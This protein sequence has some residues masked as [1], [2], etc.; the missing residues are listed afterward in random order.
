MFYMFNTI[1]WW[2]AW[3]ELDWRI[4][5]ERFVAKFGVVLRNFGNISVGALSDFGGDLI[6]FVKKTFKKEKNTLDSFLFC[7]DK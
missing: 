3:V 6:C 5:G 7:F 4:H 2:L 1:I